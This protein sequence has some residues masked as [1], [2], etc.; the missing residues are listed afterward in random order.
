MGL[1][2]FPEA[3]LAHGALVGE[4]GEAAVGE[5]HRVDL[6]QQLVGC[7]E[8]AGGDEITHLAGNSGQIPGLFLLLVQRLSGEEQQQRHRCR[9]CGAR[10]GDG[11]QGSASVP[12]LPVGRSCP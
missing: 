8:V 9:R 12:F 6:L 5:R 7:V 10:D 2:R 11:D 4:Q 3:P 1:A